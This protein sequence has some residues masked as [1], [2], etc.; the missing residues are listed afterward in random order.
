M[1]ARWHA[2]RG[3]SFALAMRFTMRYTLANMRTFTVPQAAK[4]RRVHPVTIRLWLAK[5]KLPDRRVPGT[6]KHIILESDLFPQQPSK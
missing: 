4:L 1:C 6:K 5:G 3:F 2:R